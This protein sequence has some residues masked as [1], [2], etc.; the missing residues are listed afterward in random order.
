M[1]TY[2]SQTTRQRAARDILLQVVI[3]V[4]NL[5]IGVVV[6]ALVVRRLGEAGYGQWSTVL[7]VLT[8]IGL[9]A[10]FGMETIALQEAARE[11]E[12]EHEWIGAVM[13]VRLLIL[14]PVVALSVAAVLALQQSHDMLL[15][16]LILVL[17]TPFS[18][19]GALALVFRLRV[20]NLVPMLVLTLRSVLWAIAVAVVYWQGGGLVELAIGLSATTAIGTIVQSIAAIRLADRLPRPSRAKLAP[21]LRASIP[22]GIS[23]MLILAY[24]R[25]DQVLVFSIAGNKAAGLYG[26][27]Y[28]VLDQSHFVPISILTTLAPVMAASW[29]GDRARLLRTARLT[30]ELMAVASFGALAFAIVAAKPLVKAIFG[31]HF[32]DAAPALPVL[33][34]AFVL[35]CFGYLN[36]NLLV[37]LGLQRKLLLVSLAALAVNLVGN[38]IAIS[39]FGFMGAAWMTLVTELVVFASTLTLILRRLELPPQMP[40]RI[41]RT[42][43]ASVL[44]GGAL[45]LLRLA[46]ASLTV[47]VLAACVIYPVLLLALRA[48]EPDDIRLVLRRGVAA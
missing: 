39:E 21:L 1:T 22:V 28:N 2:P 47:L 27:V 43:V 11:P 10:N 4:L 19:A 8:L 45:E 6:T 13:M 30:A 12:R 18:G 26:S 17:T 7:I 40:G 16:G 14:G 42:L 24:A 31:A 9:I 41:G 48:L 23:G 25:I 3:R 44:L 36:G 33:G 15:A 20:K 5:A 34:G 46:D 29:P 35:I 38:V 32:V 37:V